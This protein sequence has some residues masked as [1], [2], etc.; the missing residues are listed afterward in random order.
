MS[1][2]DFTL[3]GLPHLT[4]V[5]STIVAAVFFTRLLRSRAPQTV[6]DRACRTLGILLLAAIVADPLL[7]YLRHGITFLVQT[8]LP[9]YLCDAASLLLGIALLTR[10][11]RCAETG[12]FWGLAG[13]SQGL[14][15]PTLQHSWDQPEYYAFF[16]QHGGVPVAA[17]ALA[18][19]AGLGPQPG[20]W[21]R[22][23]RWSW[24][25]MAIIFAITFVLSTNYGFLNAKPEVPTLL[26]HLGP[27]PWYLLSLQA[28][29]FTL[30]WLLYLP[31][32]KPRAI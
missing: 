2:S 30:Y 21:W 22:I 28:I 24:V 29:A 1:P 15:T 7:S 5:A 12:Y 8:T 13:T 19:G 18:W 3:F 6:K 4:A 32:R 14:L 17:I 10:H 25:Y 23:V 20:A 27:W 11:Q 16:L 31:F 26:D 9:F